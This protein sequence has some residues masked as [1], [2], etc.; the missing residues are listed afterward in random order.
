MRMRVVLVDEDNYYGFDFVDNNRSLKW[1]F[2]GWAIGVVVV[3]RRE[4]VS[5][6]L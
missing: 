6:S 3:V 5:P 2:D 1:S 4:D